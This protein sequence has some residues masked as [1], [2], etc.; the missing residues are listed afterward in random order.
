MNLCV[1]NIFVCSMLVF[2]TKFVVILNT[3]IGRDCPE[4]ISCRIS[5]RG[6]SWQFTADSDCVD[7]HNSLYQAVLFV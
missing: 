7:I 2:S 6:E 1:C 4:A 3:G 5:W